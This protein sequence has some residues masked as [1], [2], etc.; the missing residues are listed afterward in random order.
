MAV[1]L[2][3]LPENCRNRILHFCLLQHTWVVVNSSKPTAPGLLR[4][5]TQLRKE[6]TMMF[7]REN[8]FLLLLR[9]LAL[10]QGHWIHGVAH[11]SN[12]PVITRVRERKGPPR[13]PQKWLSAFYNDRT[14]I[15]WTPFRPGSTL[16]SKHSL[17]NVLGYGFLIASVL[18]TQRRKIEGKGDDEEDKKRQR[19]AELVLEVWCETAKRARTLGEHLRGCD[20]EFYRRAM[21]SFDKYH[22]SPRNYSSLE[23]TQAKTTLE[24]AF[25]IIDIMQ[26]DD[27]QVVQ[28]VLE[29]W[30]QT[31]HVGSVQWLRA[32]GGNVLVTG[33]CGPRR[34]DPHWLR[35]RETITRQER[36]V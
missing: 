22:Y 32:S 25:G 18:K 28:R 1:T 15:Q 33:R 4:T 7:Y 21:K 29:Y 8:T 19:S 34:Q 17:V 11:V 31:M 35:S 9:N 3:T 24:D 14:R 6:G 26:D 13:S 23:G 27:W 36:V 30:I 16:R 10:P 20:G 12:K 5:C 2:L